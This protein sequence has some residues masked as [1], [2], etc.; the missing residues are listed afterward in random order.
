MFE[1]TV[2]ILGAKLEN[3]TDG[4]A[5]DLSHN[6]VTLCTFAAPVLE[7]PETTFPMKL[8]ARSL[9]RCES[10]RESD[11]LP[12]HHLLDTGISAGVVDSRLADVHALLDDILYIFPESLQVV[13]RSDGRPIAFATL[14]PMDA[15]SLAH[16]PAS[17]TAAL[18]DRLADE[19]ELYQ[20]MQHG[21]SDTTLS[22]LS[23]VAPEAETEEYTFFDLL[24]ALKVTGWSELAQGQRCLLLNTSPPVDMFYSQLGYRRL[25]SRADHAS[26][27]HVYAL[28]F[29]KESIAKWLIPLLLGSSADEV[30][31][32]KPTWALT[33]ESVRDC[34]KNIHN[35]QKL[36]ES[37]V[38][39]KLGRS[40]QQ[41][42]TELRE[43]LFE[44]PPRAPLTEEFQMVL[45]KTYLHG[46]PNVVA[47]T[48]SLNVGRATY[49]RRL[50]N[51]LSALTNV[52]R[53]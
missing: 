13:H 5:Y 37:D 36:D 22:L 23:C 9:P 3:S 50:D 43:A 30:S 40:G 42:Q 24:L 16:L 38:A 46:K 52:L 26:L 27:V 6:L 41:L 4:V 2:H 1:R 47:I 53:G 18:Q 48:N 29:R 34:L 20:H 8:S 31:A 35:A 19:W 12:L 17:I 51:A 44:S 39:K 7:F 14:L 33:K 11:V 32:R 21:E 10:V 25:S 28:D 45:Q 15:M 49:Y